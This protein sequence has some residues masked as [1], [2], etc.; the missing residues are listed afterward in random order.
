MQMMVPTYKRASRS[1]PKSASLETKYLHLRQ[2]LP[3]G[4]WIDGWRVCWIGGWDKQHVFFV[5]MLVRVQR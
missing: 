5:V 3:L 4:H 2:P 1:Q